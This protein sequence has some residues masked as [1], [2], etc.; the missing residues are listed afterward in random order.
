[1]FIHSQIK[2]SDHFATQ[3][4][5]KITEMGCFLLLVLQLGR[6]WLFPTIQNENYGVHNDVRFEFLSKL[7]SSEHVQLIFLSK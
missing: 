3:K 1:M 5:R 6:V 7:F 4:E 2:L